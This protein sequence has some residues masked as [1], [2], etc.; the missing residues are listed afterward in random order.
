MSGSVNS[1]AHRFFLLFSFLSCSLAV[2]LKCGTN[3]L[4]SSTGWRIAQA[5]ACANSR[6][7][8]GFFTNPKAP[9]CRSS[10][11]FSSFAKPEE[12]KI[13]AFGSRVRIFR[14]RASRSGSTRRPRTGLEMGSTMLE[15]WGRTELSNR[16]A[17]APHVNMIFDQFPDT[18]FKLNVIIGDWIELSNSGGSFR[19]SFRRRVPGKG[20]GGDFGQ[21]SCAASGFSS[22]LC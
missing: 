3:Q 16:F 8:Y 20:A 2:D 15:A 4:G 7:R 9:A 13:F 1:I 18:R 5:T 17:I 6:R 14:R 19:E 11:I 12:I 10:S 22:S 21:G